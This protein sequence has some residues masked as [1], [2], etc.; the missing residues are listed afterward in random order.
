MDERDTC[1]VGERLV[2]AGACGLVGIPILGQHDGHADDPGE[3]GV[4]APAAIHTYDPYAPD[5]WASP[6]A[7]YTWLRC[8]ARRDHGR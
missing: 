5:L 2:G 4:T 8:P 3:A 7:T 6:Y 1:H